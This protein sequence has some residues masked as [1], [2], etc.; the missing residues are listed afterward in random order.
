MKEIYVFIVENKELAKALIRDHFNKEGI[1]YAALVA[2]DKREELT[3]ALD[4]I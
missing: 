4:K 1:T 3:E 2:E